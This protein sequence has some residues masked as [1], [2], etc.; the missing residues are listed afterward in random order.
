[1]RLRFTWGWQSAF[2]AHDG[3]R[4]VKTQVTAIT[5]TIWLARHAQPLVEPGICYGQLDV[6][7]D[8][9]AT[10]AGARALAAVL[11]A[12][13]RIVCSPL[14]RCEL[15]AHALCGLRA[16]LT[17]KT[18]PRL[19]ELDFGAW[20]GRRWDDI[21]QTAL[22]SWVADFAHHRPGGGE[23]MAQFMQ[24]VASA[25]DDARQTPLTLWVT[26]AGV[27]RAATLIQAGQRRVDQA[28]HW[29]VATT[30]FGEWAILVA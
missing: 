16:D 22:D 6:A 8:A 3:R 24:R 20:E 19:M 12:A 1:M 27:I 10:T 29:P 17:Y 13:T 26:H 15:L 21:G 7:A 25:W 9:V 2:E 18:D 23:S 14:Q 28:A 30:G 11:P 4:S 5:S